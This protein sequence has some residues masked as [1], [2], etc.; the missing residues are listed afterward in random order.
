M[1]LPALFARFILPAM[2]G[3][4]LALVWPSDRN[5]ADSNHPKGDFTRRNTPSQNTT[6][7]RTR[8]SVRPSS[9]VND[10]FSKAWRQLLRE[11]DDS[12]D[13]W[14]RRQA[15]LKDWADHDLRAALGAVFADDSCNPHTAFS[16]FPSLLT[17][18]D[19]VIRRRPLEFFD[20]L[21]GDPFG[22]DSGLV[23]RHALAT[24]ARSEP[25]FIPTIL[26]QLGRADRVKAL[27]ICLG[28]PK[29][30]TQRR[31]DL[32]RS[33]GRLPDD[34]V[35]RALFRTAGRHLASQDEQV[36]LASYSAA[37]SDGERHILT[38]ALQ[39]KLLAA[40]G[41]R[42]EIAGR[43]E[44]LPEGVTSSILAQTLDDPQG[45][46]GAFTLALDRALDQPAW[47]GR[48]KELCM[49][50]HQLQLQG[51]E[52]YS[53]ELAQW[54]SGLPERDD[55]ED[56]YR[57][58]MRSLIYGDPEKAWQRIEAMPGGW[59][60]DNAFLEMVNRAVHT[61]SDEAAA[62]RALEQIESEHFRAQAA[63]MIDK[64]KANKA[65]S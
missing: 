36:L 13:V 28:S 31:D 18:F 23:R 8:S 58:A 25:G 42:A 51:G 29:L 33:L 27:T 11:P 3:V 9:S 40:R 60:R 17:A 19:D 48:E 35:N 15:L 21:K 55:C 45:H 32:I 37:Q 56:L 49:R 10:E 22:L 44:A 61:L 20:L 26:D 64:A 54:A 50:L 41:T 38:S 46:A 2:A 34:P 7:A 47:P 30:D 14:K 53:D 24:I 65:G 62:R 1:K 16:P 57:V 63:D 43:L 59:K 52:R 12:E 39:S 5:R 4:V 6:E